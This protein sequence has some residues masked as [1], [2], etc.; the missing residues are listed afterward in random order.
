M[1][2]L[3]RLT[4]VLGLILLTAC[5]RPPEAPRLDLEHSSFGVLAG[6]QNDD[7]AEALNA[8]QRS[9]GAFAAL[10]D[11]RSVG[12]VGGTVA[13]WRPACEAAAGVDSGA[14]RAFFEAWFTPFRASNR[15]A[16]EGLFTGYYEPLLRG[17]RQFGGVFTVPL[18]GRPSGLVTVDLGRFAGDL[19]GRKIIGRVVDGTVAPLPDRGEIAAGALDG[20]A[21]VIAWVDDPVDAFFLHVQGSGRVVLADGGMLR[22]GYD[23]ANGHAYTSIG[24]VLIERGEIARADV[25]LQSIRAWLGGHPDQAA[26]LL[27]ANRSYVFFREIKGDGPLGAQGVALTPG[28]SLAIDRRFLSLGVPVW[29]DI[30]ASGTSPGDADRPVRR[31]VIAQD[32]GGAI[33]GPVRGDV[34]WG[35]GPEAEYVAGHMKHRGGYYLL[36]PNSVAQGLP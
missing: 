25:S 14:A 8:F 23:G 29:L 33:R 6:W 16:S 20:D 17:A 11:D 31:L 13:D 9:C 2:P 12:P 28:R 22:V 19:E 3:F 10:P 7:Q 15:G 21:P 1:G 30:T 4:A 18:H 35:F 36:L 32:T 24:K 26:D 5:A 27:A 34:F